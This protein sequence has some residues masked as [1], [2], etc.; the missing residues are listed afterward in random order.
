MATLDGAKF[1]KHLQGVTMLLE[2]LQGEE[3]LLAETQA[4][5]V[6]TILSMLASA[7]MQFPLT[8]KCVGLVRK[9]PL[10]ESQKLSIMKALEKS[11]TAEITAK[12]GLD[13]NKTQDYCNCIFYF[14]Q[15]LW[16]II[17]GDADEM[18]KVLAIA[19]LL[20]G[21]GMLVPSEPTCCMILALALYQSPTE[22]TGPALHEMLKTTKKQIKS[23]ICNPLKKDIKF[24]VQ[25]VLPS[26]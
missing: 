24:A 12:T 20:G 15:E 21:I 9:M 3:D 17:L 7:S 14:T 11:V 4:N 22:F 2:S 5:H 10:F 16:D 8:A 13:G 26:C 1:E 23:K 18:A 6:D 25:W 19:K